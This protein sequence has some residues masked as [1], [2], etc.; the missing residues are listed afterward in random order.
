MRENL[1]RK[2]HAGSSAADDGALLLCETPPVKRGAAQVPESER[3]LEDTTWRRH[4]GIL[5]P[6]LIIYFALAFYRIDHQS[7]WVDEV[8]SIR[9][10]AP[11]E[12][13]LAREHWFGGRDPLYSM[14][15]SLWGRWATS[16]FALRSFS[17][18][19]GGITVALAYLIGLQLGKPRAAWIGATL[20]ATSPFLIWYSQ[21]VRYVILMITAGLFAMYTFRLALFTQ[22]L[23]W[24]R[25]YCCSLVLAVS[26]F[27]VN[28]FLPVAH[29]LYLLCSPSHRPMLRRWLIC[30]LLLLPLF[31]WW[32]NAGHVW[33]LGGYWQALYT[34]ITA[35]GEQEPSSDRIKGLSVGGSREFTAMALPYTFFAFS[36]G[37]SQGPSLRELH[38]SRSLA[39]LWPHALILFILSL[40]YGSLLLWGFIALWRDPD[41]GRFLALWLAVP[42]VGALG[43]SAII[44][45]MAYNVRYVAMSLPA[46]T[47]II[48][49]GIARVRRP[50]MQLILIAAVL[51]ANSLSLANYY[52]D[53]RYSR[54]DARSAARYLEAMA[55]PR[56]IIVVVGNGAPLQYYYQGTLPVVVW[57]RTV[58]SNQSVLTDQLQEL[59][60]VYRH[61]WLVVIRLWQA[62]PTGTAKQALEAKSNLIQHQE[63]PG[64]DIY[65]YRLD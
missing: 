47:L 32:A 17:A 12:P 50:T 10:A 44:P 27:V 5:I 22:R 26:A 21:E 45:A 56:D 35:S 33:Q 15:L 52:F 20:L 63:F 39:T 62:D 14:L 31:I 58:I 48:S 38:F 55:Q 1:I 30:Q 23:G 42:I 64:I 40:L 51:C 43:V 2:L 49:A 4:V 16:E 8:L 29:G 57:N 18:L 9:D 65:S 61:V 13:F 25:V 53:S 28:I 6:I 34:K 24:W 59:H 19:I 3:T 54:E 60:A 7:L 37:F 46:F 36:T 41:L 11:N